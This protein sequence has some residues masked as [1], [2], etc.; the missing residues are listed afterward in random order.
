MTL[1]Y[2]SYITFALRMAFL[3][4][5]KMVFEFYFTRGVL[6]HIVLRMTFRFQFTNDAR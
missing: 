6:V 2:F 5:L 4:L 1:A 3:V